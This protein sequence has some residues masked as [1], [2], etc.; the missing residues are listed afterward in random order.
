MRRFLL[1]FVAVVIFVVFVLFSVTYTVRFTEEA[2]LSTFGKAST[3]SVQSEPGLKW[4]WPA[5]IQ[6]VTSYDTRTRLLKTPSETQQT[7]DNQ[8][9]II[10][11]FITWRVA[12]PLVFYQRFS[13]EGSEARRHYAAAEGALR[14]QLRSALS[15]V[16]R[17]RV[18]ELLSSAPGG[19]RLAELEK[20]V[21]DRMISQSADN[22]GS[23]VGEWGVKVELAG[24]SRIVL[25]EETTKDVFARMKA[26][27]ERLAAAAEG[28]GEAVASTIMTK[29]RTDSDRILN[30]ADQRAERIRNRG[31]KEAAQYIATLN[32]DPDLAIFNAQMD[33]LRNLWSKNTTLILS[34]DIAGLTVF[35]PNM[36]DTLDPETG[37]PPFSGDGVTQKE[38][39]NDSRAAAADKKRDRRALGGSRP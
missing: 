31:E 27:R 37:L 36:L 3:E 13:G 14:S 7:A 11:A 22:S 38:D 28:Q 35:N 24:I 4:R 12:D 29:A 19:S 10:E 16:S 5:P 15:E 39:D 6:S 2:V 33:L 8:Q 9:I 34:T 18:G 26:T 1:L 25:P 17:F 21:L 20:A 32:T 23:L 30:F